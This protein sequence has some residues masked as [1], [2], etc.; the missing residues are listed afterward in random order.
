MTIERQTTTTYY[1]PT[2][3]RRYFTKSAAIKAEAKAIIKKHFPDERGCSEPFCEC[4]DPGW[5][6][7]IDQPERWSRYYRKL[8]AALRKTP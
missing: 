8:C 7:E 4:G 1:A 6:L 5:S 2:K 3:R